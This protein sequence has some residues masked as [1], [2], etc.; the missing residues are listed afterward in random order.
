MPALIR[1]FHEAKMSNEPE[2][3][4]WGTGSPKREFLHVD[5]MADACV[6]LMENYDA[7][8]TGEFVNIGVGKD[9]PI[10]E[11]VEMI[12]DIVGY[13]GRIVYDTTKPD[14]T[15]QKLLDVTKLNGLGWEAKISL[16]DGIE[17]T[18]K[19]YT[20]HLNR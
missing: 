1:K 16:R 5:D 2:V 4:V 19:W 3:L 17:Q 20:E 7:S 8:E 14:G 13:E 9:L 6:Y 18:Y 10:R 11:L 15:P 12:G